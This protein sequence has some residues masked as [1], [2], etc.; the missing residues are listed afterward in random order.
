MKLR[1]IFTLAL[2]ALTCSSGIAQNIKIDTPNITMMLSAPKD[3]NLQIVYFGKH[4][5]DA[6]ADA[7][8]ES[9]PDAIDA[10]PAYGLNCQ[11][12]SAIAV[13]HPDGNMTLELKV[14]K[15][16]TET[17]DDFTITRI[18][19]TDKAY[20]FDVDVCYKAY[21]TVDMIETWTEITNHEKKTVVLNQF[22]SGYLPIRR[23]NVWLSSLYGQWANET[24]LCE[25]PLTPG[26]KVIKNKDGVR[27]S[28]TAHAEV[29][30][31]LD[32]KPR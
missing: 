23:G 2:V 28:H 18:T 14:T 4:I 21:K 7:L 12:E 9:A 16:L 3:G 26:M 24:R 11:A 31:S 25:E 8:R 17:L 30:F 15:T 5:S 32:G 20:P 19:L 27:N 6:D 1:I 10:Y 13:L 29:M 22:D